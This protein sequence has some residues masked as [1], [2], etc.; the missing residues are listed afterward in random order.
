MDAGGETQLV[1]GEIVS[2]NYF[3]VLGVRISAGRPFRP[4][5]S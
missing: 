3:D 4:D 2:G 5:N 1:Q